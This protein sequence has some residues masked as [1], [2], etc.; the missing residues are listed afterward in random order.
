MDPLD[1]L[2]S[3]W[4]DLPDSPSVQPR[5][6][7][8]RQKAA[9][10]LALIWGSTILLH[11]VTG[12]IWLVYGVM[13]LMSLQTLRYW[14]ARPRALPDA[15]TG[16]VTDLPFVSL[17][18]AAKNEEAVI[19][20]LVENLCQV[21]YPRQCYEVWVI[22][23]NSSDRT[24]DILDGLQKTYPQLRVL[25]RLPGA[26]GGKSGALNQVLPLAKGDIIG[27][28]D[29][30]ARIE[31][32]L[33]RQVIKRF[34]EPKI[35]AVQVRKTISNADLN[36]YTEG[37]NAEMALDAYYQQQRIA[38]AGMGELRGNGQFVRRQAMERCGGWNEETITDDLDL[39]LK[40]HLH[41]WDID[42]LMDP[43]VKEEGVTTEIALWHQRNRWGEGGYQSYLDYW[44]PLLQN[45]LGLGK[46][47]DVLF[48]FLIKYA[49]PTATVPDFVMAILRSRP[50]LLI[51]LTS[52]SVTISLIGMVKGLAQSQK[53]SSQK[54]SPLRLFWTSLMGTLYMFH[55]LP[56]VSSVT[57]RMAV[58]AKRLKWVKTVHHGA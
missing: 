40:L 13:V 29:A 50:P 38:I 27:V 5:S 9:L 46:S 56:V 24:P 25:R 58:R 43:G 22:D 57:V 32:H 3:E 23:D 33:L 44:R 49:I 35:G 54:L 10:A 15:G 48:W 47:L 51:P 31:P 39:S 1:D 8:R 20:R 41:H 26:G 19:G 30:D 34:Q 16:E 55:W 11:L 18:V 37:Q 2:L 17:M 6:E 36:I 53:E 28:F 52:L 45:R 42:L 7:G 14:W 21:D 12:G 4:V